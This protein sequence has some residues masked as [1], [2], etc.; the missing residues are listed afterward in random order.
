MLIRQA[1]LERI[2]SGEIRVAFRRWRRPTV[3][4][5]GTLTTAAGVLAIDA[6]ERVTDV[7]ESDARRAGYASRGELLTALRARD[8]ADIYRIELRFVGAD[9]RIRLRLTE[10]DDAEAQ[11]LLAR[12]ERLDRAGPDGAW[13]AAALRSIRDHEAVR[14]ADL[15][16]AMGVATADF[17]RN[18]RKL[19][20]LGLTESLEVGYRLSPRGRALLKRLGS[21]TGAGAERGPAARAR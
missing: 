4:A 17:K 19:K 21:A 6:V 18:V 15:A 2:V 11:A 20:N 9:P 3:K 14:A 1:H 13:T 16:A 7:T 10:P 12:L 5:G 8:D